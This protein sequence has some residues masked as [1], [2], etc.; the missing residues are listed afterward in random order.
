MAAFEPMVTPEYRALQ[1]QKMGDLNVIASRQ[2]VLL[3]CILLRV[4]CVVAALVF[5]K[6]AAIGPIQMTFGLSILGSMLFFFLLAMRTH[7]IIVSV[8]LVLF[9]W[10]PIV[11]LL[12]LV[13][14]NGKATRMLRDGGYSVGLLGARGR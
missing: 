12:I 14:V 13:L 4:F 1:S 2:R 10:I 7:G 8:V 6:S 11:G 9:V 3:I 5:G